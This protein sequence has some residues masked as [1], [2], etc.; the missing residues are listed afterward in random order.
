MSLIVQFDP[1]VVSVL[2]SP[3]VHVAVARQ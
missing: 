1:P 2:G 3:T